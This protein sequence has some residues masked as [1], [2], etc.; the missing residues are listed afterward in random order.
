MRHQPQKDLI[1]SFFGIPQHQ[2]GYL[3]YVPHKCKIVSS[4]DVIFDESL[5][6]ALAYT[7]QPY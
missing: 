1:G 4:Y 5:F 6:I 3:V 7:Y 2:K